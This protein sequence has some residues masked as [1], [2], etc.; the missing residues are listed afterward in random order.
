MAG[1]RFD[2]SILERNLE[3]MR[4]LAALEIYANTQAQNLQSYIKQNRP[5]TDRTGEAR[6]R[7]TATVSDLPEGKGYRITLAHGVDYG[8]WL[9]LA[10]EKRF[11]ILEPTVRLKGPEVVR[12]LENLLD[13]MKTKL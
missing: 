3:T 2:T 9:E 12:G 7:L 8:V 13:A 6:K 1:I 5:W 11:A 4:K 10:H